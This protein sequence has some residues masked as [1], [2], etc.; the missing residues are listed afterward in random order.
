M[1]WIQAVLLLVFLIAILLFAVQN[2]QAVTVSFLKWSAAFPQAL[3]IVLVYLLGMVSG[4]T[5]VSFVGR[6]LR[7]VRERRDRA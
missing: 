2:T 6:S 4:W 5:V 1:R 7:K 3:L